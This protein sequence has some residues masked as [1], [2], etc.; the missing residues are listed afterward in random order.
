MKEAGGALTFQLHPVV[1]RL[2]DAAYHLAVV[3]LYYQELVVTIIWYHA[4]LLG[5]LVV[6]GLD[7]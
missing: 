6:L 5:H 3:T 1:A 7:L 2:K 4:Y